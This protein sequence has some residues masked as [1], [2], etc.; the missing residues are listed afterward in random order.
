VAV[1]EASRQLT[2]RTQEID[3]AVDSLFQAA[4]AQGGFNKIADL[5]KSTPN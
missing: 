4:S 1:L 2:E 5:K 3:S